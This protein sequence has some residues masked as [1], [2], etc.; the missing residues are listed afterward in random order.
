[1][2]LIHK[3]ICFRKRSKTHPNVIDIATHAHMNTWVKTAPMSRDN[4]ASNLKNIFQMKRNALDIGKIGRTF[5]GLNPI[6]KVKMNR[7]RGRSPQFLP[8]VLYHKDSEE[9]E[10][11]GSQYS[12]ERVKVL[13]GDHLVTSEE[14]FAAEEKVLRMSRCLDD[15]DALVMQ[16]CEEQQLDLGPLSQETDVCLGSC[17]IL[18]T[19][20][21]QVL[22][23]LLQGKRAES[24]DA[25]FLLKRCGPRDILGT[26]SEIRP[27]RDIMVSKA[28]SRSLDIEDKKYRMCASAERLDIGSKQMSILSPQMEETTV[29]TMIITQ[30]SEE[31]EEQ[32]ELNEIINAKELKED[33]EDEVFA[34]SGNVSPGD[35]Q[36][37]K[38]EEVPGESN[39]EE[40]EIKEEAEKPGSVKWDMGEEAEETSVSTLSVT[41]LKPGQS[42]QDL[43]TDEV[44]DELKELKDSN[45]VSPNPEE[46]PEVNS[47]HSKSPLYHPCMKVSFSDGSIAYH[48]DLD[49]LD[50]GEDDDIKI[51]GAGGANPFSKLRVKMSNLQLPTMPTP[52]TKRK[53][54]EQTALQNKLKS[55]L[56]FSQCKTRIILL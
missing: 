8:A 40:E 15:V 54:A 52:E 51:A 39:K 24:M 43:S 22:S 55:Q 36:A 1:M 11:K 6:R 18:A 17:G 45:D 13:K 20:P 42:D 25:L 4:S 9:E 47:V 46:N 30:G 27:K 31:R 56:R 16:E 41:E 21:S 7:L 28:K 19:K 34:S 44:E 10:E 33:G 23:S 2:Q 50:F 3:N 49:D 38:S 53:A 32:E 48:G 5:A 12:L 37:E 14:A 29:P 26:Y 35:S